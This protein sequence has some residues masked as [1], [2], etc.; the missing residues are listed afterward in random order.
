MDK[1]I[2]NL[3][4][5]SFAFMAMTGCTG[6]G[7][8]SNANAAATE[9]RSTRVKTFAVSAQTFESRVAVQGS[10][11]AKESAN[12][13]ALVAG[14]I[15]DIWVDEGDKVTGGKS[16]LFQIDQESLSNKVVVAEQA[17]AVARSQHEVAKASLESIKASLDKALLDYNRY[18][19]LHDEK[20]V[21][22]NEFE[23]RDTNLRQ[24]RANLAVGEAQIALSLQQIEQAEAQLLI[25]QK[26]LKDSLAVAP[27]SGY[28]SVRNFDSGEFVGVGEVVVSIVD[29]ENLE[30]AAFVPA[31]HFE[32]IKVGETKLR[33]SKLGREVGEVTVTYRSPIVD[34]TLR[35]FE[36]KATLNGESAGSFA[37]GMMVDGE[38]IFDSHSA[39]GI[40]A[41]SVLSRNGE[42]VVFVALDGRA[43]QRTIKTGENTDGR[44]E[45]LSGLSSGELVI[46]EGHT[47]VRDGSAV[48]IVK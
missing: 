22:D 41:S 9:E 6:G 30:A 26:A 2:Y 40:P 34:T 37:P 28:V 10:I 33:L 23:L 31:R 3:I 48:E 14:T 46:S 45:I 1:Y 42:S 16:R 47:I 25:S 4:A 11:E 7:K 8:D 44:I 20:R 43:K 18:K 27:I 13:G 39:L 21:T 12:V 32:K 5:A 24:A 19:R 38:L 17:L 29:V 36:I 35:T 15:E